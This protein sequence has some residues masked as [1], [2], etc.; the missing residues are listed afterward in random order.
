MPKI[1]LFN[2]I[3]VDYPQFKFVKSNKF[4]WSPND[5]TIYYENSSDWSSLLHELSHAILNHTDY[6]MDIELVQMEAQAWQVAREKLAPKYKIEINID[7]EDRGLETYREW[8]HNRSLCPRCGLN[9][10]QKLDLT[11]ICP[12]CGSPWTVNEAK[13]TQL[14][15]RQITSMPKLTI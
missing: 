5:K 13:F 1:D 10:Y 8:I 15:R 14:K 4:M 11:Y 7:A 12:S 9:G 2:Q 6:H 3:K